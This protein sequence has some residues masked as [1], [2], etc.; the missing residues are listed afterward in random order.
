VTVDG[1][2]F[3]A[4]YSATQAA[5]T[6]A[7]GG[8]GPTLIEAKTYRFDEHCVGLFINGAYRTKEE[9]ERYKTQ[10]DPIALFRAKLLERGKS[11]AELSKTDEQARERVE[12]AVRF[13]KD[14][15]RPEPE[16]AFDL[17]HASRI[18]IRR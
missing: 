10:R 16:E 3:D 4:V 5:V 13:A 15:P 1:Q 6:R 12:A 9:V 18:P 8:E 14:S 7:R 2:D 17:V 11:V